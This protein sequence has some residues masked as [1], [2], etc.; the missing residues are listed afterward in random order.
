MRVRKDGKNATSGTRRIRNVERR[1]LTSDFTWI[2]R[3]MYYNKGMSG[4][5]K[6]F[7]LQPK[8]RKQSYGQQ[9]FRFEPMDL[10]ETKVNL[11]GA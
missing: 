11:S 3:I 2:G 5:H 8:P 10:V 1:N 7:S 4:Y 9:L 6:Y